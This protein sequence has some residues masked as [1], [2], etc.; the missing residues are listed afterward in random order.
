MVEVEDCQGT[1]SDFQAA[2]ALEELRIAVAAATVVVAAA[3]G[4]AFGR[5]S[6][7]VHDVPLG[8]VSRD[9]SA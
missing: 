6:L 4:G 3:K 5:G 2:R 9:T 7:L 8:L 1:S